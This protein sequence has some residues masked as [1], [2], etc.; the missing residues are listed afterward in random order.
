[1]FADANLSAK[2]DIFFYR[3]T[4][5]KACLGGDY[6][7][8]SDLAV[9]AN[10]NQIIDF[11]ASPDAG[12]VEGSAV[13]GGVGADLDI[14]F[15]FQTSD[16]RKLFITASRL[17]THIAEAVAAK[18]CAGV[19]DYA[20]SKTHARI[21]RHVRI[22]ITTR[23]D[24]YVRANYAACSDSRVLSDPRTF[25]DHDSLFNRNSVSQPC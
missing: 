21:N 5:G 10:V 24:A 1:M 9:V 4:A 12:C 20:V 15:D 3:N 18:H 2:H 17:V 19:D 6:H 11:R 23:S 22:E 16:L 13:D 14:V 8:F 25:A 7:I